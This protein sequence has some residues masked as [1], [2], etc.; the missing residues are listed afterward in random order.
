LIGQTSDQLFGRGPAAGLCVAGKN[1]QQS[2]DQ[3]F[4]GPELF[5]HIHRLKH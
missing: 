2:G 4:P 1:R 5:P 3:P